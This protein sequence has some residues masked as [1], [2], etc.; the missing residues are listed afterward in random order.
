[1]FREFLREL[2]FS[3]VPISRKPIF[4]AG[5]RAFWPPRRELLV[6]G[7]R[8]ARLCSVSGM[9]CNGLLTVD[10]FGPSET[11]CR[12][13]IPDAIVINILNPCWVWKRA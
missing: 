13:E 12:I 7:H 11:F 5:L 1:M 6:R 9:L 2:A 10:E 4:Y 8:I 3:G